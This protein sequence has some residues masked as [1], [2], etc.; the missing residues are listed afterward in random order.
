MSPHSKWQLA[1]LVIVATLVLTPLPTAVASLTGSDGRTYAQRAFAAKISREVAAR[2]TTDNCNQPA[3]NTQFCVWNH[4][5]RGVR[6]RYSGTYLVK[7][8]RV[9]GVCKVIVTAD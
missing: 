4:P 9:G 3:K 7:A 2:F 5:D 1:S 6:V 8:R